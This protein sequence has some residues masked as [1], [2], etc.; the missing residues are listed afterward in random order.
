MKTP[1][2]DCRQNTILKRSNIG[3]VVCV[4]SLILQVTGDTWE[5]VVIGVL[6][7]FNAAEIVLNMVHYLDLVLLLIGLSILLYPSPVAPKTR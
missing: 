7:R 2:P 6:V 3:L 5:P 1:I 4:V